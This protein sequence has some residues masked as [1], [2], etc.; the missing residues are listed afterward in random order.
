M[1]PSCEPT[2]LLTSAD[3]KQLMNLCQQGRLY[4]IEDWIAAGKSLQV[5]Q[6]CKTT[7]L[8]IAME[9]GFH[10]LVVLLARNDVGQDAKN[11]ALLRAVST[12][13]LE[14]V[15]L[16]LKHGAD[17]SSAPFS[18]VLLS[19]EPSLI[20]F[21]GAGHRFHYRC[22]VCQ[23]IYSQGSNRA[24]P[25]LGMQAEPSGTGRSTAEAGGRSTSVFL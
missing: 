12:R 4:E 9:C 18:D 10:S 21:F 25:L 5:H 24:S 22:A 7:P 16:L 14:F 15:E 8:Q 2:R 23:S 17:F 1:P 20:R 6:E 13:N 3:A 19:W 11:H